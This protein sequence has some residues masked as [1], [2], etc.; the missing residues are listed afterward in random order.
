MESIPQASFAC[1]LTGS[2]ISP[3]S[4]AD[5]MALSQL[6]N[7]DD[8][9]VTPTHPALSSNSEMD[10]ARCAALHNYLVQY[11]WLAEGRS[12]ARLPQ[13]NG[14]NNYFASHGDAA[15]ETR[16]RLDPSVTAFLEAAMIPSSSANDGED[17][18]EEDDDD[19]SPAPFFW[20][21]SELSEPDALFADETADL[22]DQ[23]ADSLLCLYAPNI[24]G[25][26][27]G[28]FGGGL[29]YHQ[30][31]HRAA[32]FMHMDDYDFALPVET[33]PDLWHPLETVLSH[34][35]ELLR[36]G[37]VVASPRH[38]PALF[39]S[40]KMGPWEWRPYGDA[41]QVTSCVEAWHRFCDAVEGHMPPFPVVPGDAAALATGEEGAQPLVAPG[42]LDAA[43]VPET[44]FARAFLTRARRPR[45]QRVAPGLVLP[46]TDP[47][48]FAQ[49][50]AYTRLAREG[51][52]TRI[53]PVLLLFSEPQQREAA[54]MASRAFGGAGFGSVAPVPA[55]VYSEAVERTGCDNAEE[56]FRLLLPYGLAGGRRSD[57][58]LLDRGTAVDLFQHGYKPFGGSYHRPQRLERLF[59][60]W[61]T[62]VDQ[63]VW[64]VGP[65][66]VQGTLDDFG[67]ADT[68][69]WSDYCIPPTW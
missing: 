40:E 65:E 24:G 45:F 21:A 49:G 54:P 52:R 1:A 2:L 13:A 8:V 66:G 55:G 14:A 42:A 59:D 22:Y 18:N 35:I 26:G 29:L 38:A 50:Q 58:S 64:V 67:K 28:E 12:P 5:E 15:E 46:P 11:A 27:G 10:H 60:H 34:W 56:G 44:C 69:H 19:T 39:G 23:P 62:L 61:R 37:K 31:H 47:T 63:G 53:P 48:A 51:P 4:I 7:V 57:G 41:Q 43:S 36:V 68:T 17:D 3:T 16:S 32:V 20:W 9:L 33:H 6:P 30:G 25:S